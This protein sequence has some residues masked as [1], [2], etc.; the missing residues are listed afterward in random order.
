MLPW[1]PDGQFGVQNRLF[2]GWEQCVPPWLLFAGH[3]SL[4]RHTSN[5]AAQTP[6][7]QAAEL[8]RMGRHRSF[9]TGTDLKGV[10][11]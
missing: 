3:T 7:M 9:P 11:L 1:S 8:L 5:E 2:S 10:F 6:R 4:L